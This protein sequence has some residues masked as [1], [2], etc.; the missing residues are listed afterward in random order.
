MEEAREELLLGP[1]AQAPTQRLGV[2]LRG[3]R[4][5]ERTRVLVDPEREDGRLQGADRHLALGEHADQRRRQSAVLG[6]DDVLGRRP[7]GQLVAVMVEDDLFYRRIEGYRLELAESR[8]V[9]RLDDD[10]APNR[11]QLEPRRVD[12]EIELVGMEAVELANIAVER[13]GQA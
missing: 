12:D 2:T 1:V 5:R 8:G 4:M 11:I 13:A 7:V 10:Q 9:H 3:R 6:D